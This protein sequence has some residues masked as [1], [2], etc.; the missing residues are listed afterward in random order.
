VPD[1]KPVDLDALTAC[2][3]RGAQALHA[4]LTYLVGRGIFRELSPGR[5]AHVWPTL[6]TYVRTGQPA[7]LP[8]TV[9]RASRT[10]AEAGA[11]LRRCAE[12]AGTTGRVVV[13]GGVGPD[14]APRPLMIEMLLL[15]AGSLRSG[16]YAVECRAG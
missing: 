9:K 10:F 11:I 15:R 16:K 7:Y 1:A 8:A 14:D 3:R 2:R 5:F 6:P 4:V 12:A 13:L